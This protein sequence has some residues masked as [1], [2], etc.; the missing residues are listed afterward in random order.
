MPPPRA[1]LNAAG[2]W[3]ELVDHEF[4]HAFTT[5]DLRS[6]WRETSGF[7]KVPIGA[8]Y[9]GEEATAAR[10]EAATGP[11]TREI[12]RRQF[13]ALGGYVLTDVPGGRDALTRM[14]A[15]DL[16]DL[17][18]NLTPEAAPV[19]S[20]EQGSTA[21]GRSALEVWATAMRIRAPDGALAGTALVYKPAVGMTTL[22][23][24]A[25]MG[26]LGHF[27]RMLSVARPARRPAA[28]LFATSRLRL[29]FRVACRPPGTSP[30]AADSSELPTSASWTPA[31]SPAVTSATAWARSSSRRLRGPSRRL[32][33]LASPQRASCERL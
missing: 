5:D 21:W 27:A 8:F 22:G 23:A 29:P 31:A 25:G 13:K 33:A 18:G 20:Y 28:I 10:M 24:I 30:S 16:R 9:F 32:R 4:R 7:A 11:T 2:Y 3:A 1:A 15:S 17:V 6:G 14:V 26:D 12:Q 19:L